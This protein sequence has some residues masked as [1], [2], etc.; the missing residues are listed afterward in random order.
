MAEKT[1]FLSRFFKKAAQNYYVTVVSPSSPKFSDIFGTNTGLSN[2]ALIQNLETVP[3]LFSIIEWITKRITRI[4]I[5]VV[6]SK[7]KDAPDSEMWNLIKNPNKYQSF[8]ELIKLDI[9]YYELTGNSFLYGIKPDGMDMVTSLWALPVDKTEIV[10]KYD[11]SLPAWMNELSEYQSTIGGVLYHLP[12]E[13][14]LHERYFSLRYDNGSW[15]WGISK[16]IP[17]DKI[18]RELK[19]IHDAKTSIIEQRGALGFISNE[20][21]NPDPEQS[22]LVQ[23]AL[24]KYGVLDKQK[25][26]VITTEKLKWQQ[27]ALGIQELQLIENAKYSMAQLCE[28]NGFDPVIF[29]TEGSTFANKKEATRAAMFD[30]IVPMVDNR[31]ESLNEFLSEGYGGDKI[32]PDWA[33]VEEIQADRKAATDLITRQVES[34]LITPFKGSKIL[35][36]DEADENPAPDFFFRKTS[37]VPAETEIPAPVDPATLPG[38]PDPNVISADMI[39]QMIDE[40]NAKDG[41]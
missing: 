28:I 34:M 14:V 41:N 31:F 16:Y 29:S 15:V 39:R 40:N 10:L 8:K 32:V 13:M 1:R 27:M 25:K 3:Q 9:V 33:K 7:G 12:A 2:L 19:A 18:N 4:P 35:Y 30:V 20:S 37:L 24:S 22:K 11:K 26:V 17:G 6:N 36:G 38:L 23:D 5:K 21:E